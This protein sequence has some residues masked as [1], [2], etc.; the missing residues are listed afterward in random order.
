MTVAAQIAFSV[1]VLFMLFNIAMIVILTRHAIKIQSLVPVGG[2][3]FRYIKLSA[4][5]SSHKM[6]RRLVMTTIFFLSGAFISGI[7]FAITNTPS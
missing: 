5:K 2:I 6:T 1:F 3:N 7:V 4:I